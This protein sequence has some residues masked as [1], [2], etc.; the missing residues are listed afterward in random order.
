M[1]NAT[2]SSLVVVLFSLGAGNAAAQ[3]PSGFYA[4]AGLGATSN[5]VQA[6]DFSTPLALVANQNP[7][8]S[9]G[10]AVDDTTATSK[11]RNACPHPCPD[12]TL[13]AAT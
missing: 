4:L 2:R 7:T 3:D 10:Q 12:R 9:R 5:S 8:L 6:Q 13:C 11:C 1:N